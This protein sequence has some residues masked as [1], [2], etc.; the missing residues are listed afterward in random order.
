MYKNVYG[1]KNQEMES[2]YLNNMQRLCEYN[3]KE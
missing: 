2:M 3:E 1:T